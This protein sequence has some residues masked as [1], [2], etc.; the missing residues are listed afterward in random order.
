MRT[1]AI[2]DVH[3]CWRA[4]R[5]LLDAVAPGPDERLILLGDYVDRGPNTREVLD[6]LIGLHEAG[7]L[8]ALRG[9]HEQMML[10]AYQLGEVWGWMSCGGRATLAS[11]AAVPEVSDLAD[12]PERHWRFLQDHLVD[13]YETDTH[14]FV[15]ANALPD[16]PLAEQPAYALFWEK[17]ETPAPHVSGKIMVCGHT[18]QLNGVP[19]NLGHTVCIDT[20][21]YR[22]GWLT[23]LDVATGRY[24]Q[25]N[26]KEAQRTGWL[27]E[28]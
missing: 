19:L 9:N 27:E 17:L 3:G 11:Y 12:V 23:C 4:L 6:F 5:A 16:V 20:N 28:P 18:P 1:L 15:H 21:A 7:R 13:W 22:D 26:E 10:A 14:F 2:G 24:W 8:I 25:A